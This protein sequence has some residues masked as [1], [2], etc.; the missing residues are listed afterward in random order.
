MYTSTTQG[1]WWVGALILLAACHTAPDEQAYHYTRFAMETV[2]EYTIVAPSPAAAQGAMLA[3][4]VEI[5]RVAALLWEGDPRS[6]MHA[7]NHARGHVAVDAEVLAFLQ[8]ARRYHAQSA[9]AFDVTIAPVL[10]LYDFDGERGTPPTAATLAERLA[11]VGMEK[12]VPGPPGTIF[13]PAD[14]D[15]AVAVGGVAKGYAVDRAVDV[16]RAHGIRSAIVNAGGD[17][18]CLGTRHGRPWAVGIR[19]PDDA[20]ALIDTLF[21][22]DRAVATSGDYERFFVFEGQRYHH[23]LNPETGLPART[24]RSATVIAEA[25]E[26]ADALATALFVAGPDSGIARIERLPGVEGMLVDAGGRRYRTS[27]YPD[28]KP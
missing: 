26:Q 22:A 20:E 2:V 23:L 7:F 11:Q 1:G 15:V 14:R 10:D 17:M 9:G 3:A 6:A 28:N 25:A 24:A 16:L 19:D 18:Y 12:L 27:G 21:V 13:K 8:R 4:H 5:E